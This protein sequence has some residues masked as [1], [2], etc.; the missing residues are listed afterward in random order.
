MIPA[1]SL[2]KTEHFQLREMSFRQIRE[3]FRLS[4]ATVSLCRETG[5]MTSNGTGMLRGLNLLAGRNPP[6]CRSPG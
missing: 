5:G 3:F 6:Y 4:T 1:L 2:C